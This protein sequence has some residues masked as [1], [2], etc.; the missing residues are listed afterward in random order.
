MI[1]HAEHGA[2]LAAAPVFAFPAGLRMDAGVG[3]LFAG[4]VVA[5]RARSPAFAARRAGFAFAPHRLNGRGYLG[6]NSGLD[7]QS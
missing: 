1:A 7:W 2:V 6:V 3:A 4:D 5:F